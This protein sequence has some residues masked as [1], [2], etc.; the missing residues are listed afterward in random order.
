MDTVDTDKIDFRE[1]GVPEHL[2]DEVKANLEK[3]AVAEQAAF[4]EKMSPP[5]SLNIPPLLEEKR[6]AWLI[7]DAA[8]E[9][10]RGCAFDRILVRQ[11][12]MLSKTRG[13]KFDTHFGGG[14]I[15][16]SE[17][18]REVDERAAPRG[19]IVGAGMTALDSLRSH[20]Y[21]IG[22]TIMF[23]KNTV[24][25]VQCD[26]IASQWQWLSVCHI[27]DIIHSEELAAALKSGRGKIAR[28][29]KGLHHYVGSD[30]EP[31]RPIAPI[32]D[33]SM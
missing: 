6:W 3:E 20:G 16:K 28:D 10:G 18:S 22:H 13:D 1:L 25:R 27:H 7:P 32:D 15:A 29:L 24:H 26:M 19:V 23:L 31:R 5:G 14:L 12:P 4:L 9:A 30:G 33:E 17:K 11:I 2:I 8:I 21:D